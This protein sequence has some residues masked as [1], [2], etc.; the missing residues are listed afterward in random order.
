MVFIG[1]IAPPLT[2]TLCAKLSALL[3]SVSP[4]SISRMRAA[5]DRLALVCSILRDDCFA[6]L[7]TRLRS[8]PA[9]PCD[10]ARDRASPLQLSKSHRKLA[11][12][13]E[14]SRTRAADRA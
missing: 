14:L 11:E 13:V 10:R 12:S 5:G 6:K 8:S 9:L 7:P 2:V 3:R 4:S 1:F